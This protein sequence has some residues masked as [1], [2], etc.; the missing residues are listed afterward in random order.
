MWGVHACCCRGGRRVADIGLIY[1]FESLAGYFY[2]E[3][4]KPRFGEF[5]SPETDYLV[6]SDWLTNDIR[7]DFTFIHP[8]F[9]FGEKYE[10]RRWKRFK[11]Q[12]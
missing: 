3:A 8:E 11:E 1:P 10:L 6:V 7:R 4:P 2:F 5:A 9:F 12:P